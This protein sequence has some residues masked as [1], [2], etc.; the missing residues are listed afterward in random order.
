MEKYIIKF[1]RVCVYVLDGWNFVLTKSCFFCSFTS[2]S[3]VPPTFVMY[4]LSLFLYCLKPCC[5]TR[6]GGGRGVLDKTFYY[7]K[8]KGRTKSWL[9]F[10]NVASM[11]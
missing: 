10:E 5:E 4:A 1:A 2:N 11:G 7:K 6:T 9:L 3:A 8:A